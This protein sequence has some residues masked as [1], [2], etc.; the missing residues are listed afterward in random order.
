MHISTCLT[1]ATHAY[2]QNINTLLAADD[3]CDEEEIDEN[4]PLW[5][6]T[7]ARAEGDRKKALRMLEDPDS[8]MQYPE[9]KALLLEGETAAAEEED[10]EKTVD[11]TTA[12]VAAISTTDAVAAPAIVPV[13]A[14]PVVKATPGKKA[15]A[16]VEEEEDGEDTAIQEV[17]DPREHLNI[18][19]IGHVD[20]GK[21]TLSGSILY[22]MGKVDKRTIERYEREAKER[23]R[24]SWFLA[25]I[26]D[27]SE[28]ER[29]KGK[30]VEVGRAQFETDINRYTIL[31]APGHKNYVPNMISGAAQA[32]VGVLVISARKGE[33]ET[34]FEKG[35]QTREHALLART[36]GVQYL[37]VVVNKMDDPTVDWDVNRY[38]EC[39]SKLKPYLKQCGYVIKTDVKFIPISAIGGDNVLNEVA[40]SKCS[41]WKKYYTEGTHNTSTPTLLSTLDQLKMSG[42]NPTGPLRIPCLDRYLERGCVVLG[43]VESGTLRM[44]DEITIA[45]TKKKAKV[46]AIYI[47]ETKVR[48]AKPGEN[49]LIKFTINVEDIQKGYVLCSANSI[50]PAVTEVRV[51]LALVDML[52]HRPIFSPGYEAVMHVH[53]VEIEVT[54]SALVAVIDKGKQM[55]RPYARQGQQ[56]IAHLLLPISTCMEAFDVIQALGRVTIRDEGKT[57]AIGKIISLIKVAP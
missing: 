5:K 51:Q 18:V 7:L 26:M 15:A 29:A 4:D 37:V 49:V 38:E 25:F 56:C 41:W 13:A 3:D 50:C 23:N 43:K 24:E 8:L 2:T 10:W 20:A 45:P 36:L 11:A 40:D 19:F 27:T 57:I 1:N 39:V 31:D 55:R 52:E 46:D 32:D 9:I 42:R 16:P 12:E 14:A 48:S 54:C 33:F 44:D 17:V 35:G 22:I 21:S 47:G 28:E 6:A 30:T 53:T 34:G